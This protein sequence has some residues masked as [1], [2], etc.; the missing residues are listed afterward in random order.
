[1]FSAASSATTRSEARCSPSRTTIRNSA[2]TTWWRRASR[3]TTFGMDSFYHT[4]DSILMYHGCDKKREIRMET[5]LNLL[6][7]RFVLI[8]GGLVMLALVVFA[9]ALAL[10]RRG[11]LD[12]VRRYAE[13]A[14]RAA[15]RHLEK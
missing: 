7:V 5:V 10:K 2:S 11:R 6:M 8:V 15:V 3:S 14:A 9:V 4:R 1:M 13:P 12:D